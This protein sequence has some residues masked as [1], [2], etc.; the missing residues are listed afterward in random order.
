METVETRFLR[1]LTRYRMMDHKCEELEVTYIS[2]VIKTISEMA[3][4]FGKNA[5]KTKPQSW[6]ISI[7]RRLKIARGF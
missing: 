7:K 5:Q 2:T 3:R 4:A 1:A 6:S